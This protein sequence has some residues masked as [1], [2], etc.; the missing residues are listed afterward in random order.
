MP[1]NRYAREGSYVTGAVV[2]DTEGWLV[3]TMDEVVQRKIANSA[4]FYFENQLLAPIRPAQ[5]Q[6]RFCARIGPARAE[7][8]VVGEYGECV[9]VAR[10]GTVVP[11]QI[12]VNGATPEDRGPLRSGM[13][14]GD[15]VVIV[16]MDRQ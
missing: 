10:N 15:D 9:V 6:T 16:G 7:L 5:F 1:S 12:L 13:V 8:L 2:N 3:L 14:A 11:E 4:V